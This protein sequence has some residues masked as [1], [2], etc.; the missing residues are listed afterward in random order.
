MENYQEAEKALLANKVTEELI[1]SAGMNRKSK[2]YDKIFFQLYQ[3]LKAIFID[4]KNQNYLKLLKLL[5]VLQESHQYI[6]KI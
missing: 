5:V 6:G 1:C 2:T 4:K 3:L